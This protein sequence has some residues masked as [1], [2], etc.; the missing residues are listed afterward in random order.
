M[1]LVSASSVDSGPN[2]IAIVRCACQ[3][4]LFDLC[5]RFSSLPLGVKGQALHP[6]SLA[7]SSA[8]AAGTSEEEGL[9]TAVFLT[10]WGG[11]IGTS[12]FLLTMPVSTSEEKG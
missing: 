2:Q 7:A 8:T 6:P 3:L 12:P 5:V 10:F 9:H 1:Y 4:P 11:R